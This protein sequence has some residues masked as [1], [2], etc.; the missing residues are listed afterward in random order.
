M[1]SFKYVNEKRLS[2]GIVALKEYVSE[3][4]TLTVK[5]INSKKQLANVLTKQG[6]NPHMFLK[7]LNNGCL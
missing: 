2:T 7:L 1:K 3:N 5:W 6:A 4:Q